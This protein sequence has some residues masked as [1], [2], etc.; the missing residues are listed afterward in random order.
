MACATLV[1]TF[2]G[3]SILFESAIYLLITLRLPYA[4]K[5]EAEFTQLIFAFL[6]SRL[7]PSEL[8]ASGESSTI[9]PAASRMERSISPSQADL[10]IMEYKGDFDE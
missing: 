10:F 4:L 5:A 6:F 3:K 8:F 9:S 1:Y 7:T 2:S